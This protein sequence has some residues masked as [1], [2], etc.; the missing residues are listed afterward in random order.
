MVGS[1]YI[2]VVRQYQTVIDTFCAFGC[3]NSDCVFDA[4]QALC[5][6]NFLDYYKV[7]KAKMTFSVAT[8]VT[9]VV[10]LKMSLRVRPF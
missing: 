9:P 1:N 7:L 3:E 8:T 2:S 4:T 5:R 6:Y 10:G